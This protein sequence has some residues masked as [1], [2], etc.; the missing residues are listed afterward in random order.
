[1][2]DSWT[3]KVK[4]RSCGKK[5]EM[6]HSP[7]DRLEKK[8]FLTWALEHSTFPITKQCDCDNGAMLFHDLIS[9]TLSADL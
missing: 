1:M 9:Y 3:Y 6:Y 7:K 2:T 4:C 8:T 5:T